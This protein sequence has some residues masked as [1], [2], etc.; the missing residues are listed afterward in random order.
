MALQKNYVHDRY[1]GFSMFFFY[2]L[3]VFDS[4]TSMKYLQAWIRMIRARNKFGTK[5][6]PTLLIVAEKTLR[7]GQ[8]FFSLACSSPFPTYLIDSWAIFN[9]QESTVR[10]NRFTPR[11]INS[12]FLLFIFSY[13]NL[14]EKSVRLK[15]REGTLILNRT[16]LDL[17]IHRNVWTFW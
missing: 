15:D 14:K 16:T 13:R 2:S 9:G 10:R 6:R 7:R 17:N 5:Q 1:A 12:N 3:L 11:Q 4:L 8:L